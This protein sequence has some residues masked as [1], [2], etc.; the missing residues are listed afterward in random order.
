[1]PNPSYTAIQLLLDRSGSM[2]S[3]RSD[4]EGGIKTFIEDQR[5]APGKCTLRLAQFDYE[6]EL[7]HPSTPIADVPFPSLHP[8]GGTAL[9]DGWGRA[10]TEFGEELAGLPEDGRPAH[11]IFVVVTD[12]YENSSQEWSREQIFNKVTE[13][14]ETYGWQFLYLAAGQ[15]AVKEGAAYGVASAATMDWAASPKGTQAVYSAASASVLRTRSG[16]DGGFT[17]AERKSARK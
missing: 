16:N 2:V 4:A 8:R 13:Q 3:I 6:Y 9:L 17:E 14:T 11:V 12:G 10:M 5:K 15:D 7:V 1:M